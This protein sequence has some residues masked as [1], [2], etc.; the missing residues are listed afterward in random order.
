[1]IEIAVGLGVI[2]SM[3]FQEIVGVSAGGIVVP[4][5]VALQMPEN[6]AG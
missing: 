6:F 5:Y 2:L 3:I 4:G 1:M